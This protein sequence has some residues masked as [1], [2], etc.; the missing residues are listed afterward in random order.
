MNQTTLNK[1][2]DL[3][4]KAGQIAVITGAGISS[5]SG[6][7]TFR[8]QGGLWKNY[9][10]QD[11]AT[12]QAFARNPE[13]VHEW[14]SWRREICAG[15]S[16]NPAHRAVARLEQSDK[17]FL[18]I[19]QNVDGL[20]RRAGNQQLIEIHGNIFKS[21]C[22][23]CSHS[24]DHNLKPTESLPLVCPACQGR[25]RPDIVWFGEGYNSSQLDR[26]HAFLRNTDLVLV[27]GTSGMVPMPVYL[28]Q[29]AAEHGARIIDINPDRSAVSEIADLHLVGPAGTIM[30]ALLGTEL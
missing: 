15:A 26:A 4:N 22:T 1:A 27:I 2:R 3:L 21:Y 18:L 24:L 7:P 5:E 6:I 17:E 9:K 29:H 13:L 25:M 20:H 12:P 8:G 19:T 10:A 16:P 23:D 11:L 28:A 14:Y 30:P